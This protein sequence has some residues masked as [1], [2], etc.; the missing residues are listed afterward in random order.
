MQKYIFSECLF[1]TLYIEIENKNSFR[2]NKFSLIKIRKIYFAIIYLSENTFCKHISR[3]LAFG[4]L[5]TKLV[6][7]VL[8]P[9][10]AFFPNRC[11]KVIPP[12]F[13]SDKKVNILFSKI[14]S[15]SLSK[16]ESVCKITKAEKS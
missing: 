12:T 13:S 9:I 11:Q 15:D 10:K 6:Y 8:F 7:V 3:L 14:P 2:Q 16:I 5:F 4:K 1:N